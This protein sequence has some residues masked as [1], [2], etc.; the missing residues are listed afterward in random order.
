VF[1]QQDD[2]LTRKSTNLNLNRL[3]AAYKIIYSLRSSVRLIK[4]LRFIIRGPCPC[5]R[6]SLNR[7]AKKNKRN[8]FSAAEIIGRKNENKSVQRIRSSSQHSNYIQTES[9][10]SALAFNWVLQNLD[11]CA[12][13]KRV[14]VEN[15]R[16]RCQRV[17]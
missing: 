9:G 1:A 16:R 6:G 3:A 13:W 17:D 5:R 10:A 8:A 11:T 15:R 4:L 7:T 12:H 2:S 14:S